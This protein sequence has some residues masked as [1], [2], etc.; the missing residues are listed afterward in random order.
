MKKTLLI[1]CAAAVFAVACNDKDTGP[2]QTDP[3]ITVAAPLENSHYAFMD[4]VHFS[5]SVM[6]I[7]PVDSV[8]LTLQRVVPDSTVLV[9]PYKPG[10][11]VADLELGGYW[12]NNLQG[13]NI[14]M[15]A[16]FYIHDIEGNEFRDT[17]HFTCN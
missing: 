2:V 12:Q 13:T 11:P 8:S 16:I 7:R 15:R 17:T 1:V 10:T 5:I 3:E 14:P 9:F 6:H 4:S